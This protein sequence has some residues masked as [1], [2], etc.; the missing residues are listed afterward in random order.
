[1][2]RFR[3]SDQSNAFQMRSIEQNDSQKSVIMW[4]VWYKAFNNRANSTLCKSVTAIF[5][6]YQGNTLFEDT[7]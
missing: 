4:S 3:K 5:G 1:M 6:M 2:N 7:F